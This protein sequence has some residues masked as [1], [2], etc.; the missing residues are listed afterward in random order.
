MFNTLDVTLA[1]QNI[2]APQ[3]HFNSEFTV[4][5]PLTLDGE[6]VLF[7]SRKNH[8]IFGRKP[9]KQYVDEKIKSELV[10][11]PLPSIYPLSRTV[12]IF[13]RNIYRMES[14]FRK[15]SHFRNTW[16]EYVVVDL[17]VILQ[18]FDRELHSMR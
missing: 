15:L 2:D 8:L 11:K 3:Y 4:R 18:P 14:K 12:S 7:E 9:L 13:G 16:R 1:R 17:S 10:S 6:P 5:A